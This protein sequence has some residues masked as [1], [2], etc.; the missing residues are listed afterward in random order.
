MV[1]LPSVER[2]IVYLEIAADRITRLPHLLKEADRPKP[3][4]ALDTIG[5]VNHSGAHYFGLVLR[6]PSWSSDS[7]HL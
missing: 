5:L 3:L 2:G 7:I 4:Y 1:R 6:L